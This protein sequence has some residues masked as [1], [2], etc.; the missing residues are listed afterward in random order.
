MSRYSKEDLLKLVKEN[1]VKFIRLQFTDVFGT[2]KNV[3]IM[4]DSLERVLD[5]GCM[6]DGSSIDGFVRIEE[7]DMYLQ[8]DMDTFEIFPWRPQQNRVARIIC[9]V[10]TTDGVPFKGCP[11][12]ILKKVLKEAAAMGYT[13]NVG[14]ECEFFLFHTD[15]EGKPTTI[16][17]D[18]G[19]YFDLAP[20]DR[21]EDARRDICIALEE[22][23]FN[24]EASHHE[25]ARGQHE[26][27][28]KY[29]EALKTA[30]NVMTF[31]LVVKAVAQ[32]HGLYAT[33][34][35]KPIFGINGSGMH[36]NQSLSKGKKNAFYDPNDKL[37]LS[38]E[39]Y[40]FIAGMMVHIKSFSAITN[41]LVN[42][43][44]RLVPGYEAP[45]YIAWSAKNRSP[46]IRVPAASG[47]ATRIE[48][49]NPDPACNPY[50]AF[51]LMLAAGLD[52]IKK[53]MKPVPSVDRNIFHMDEEARKQEG[54]D[55]M[56]ASLYDAILEMQKNPLVKHVLGDHIYDTYIEAKMKE[57][58][59]F[60]IAV[61]PWELEKYL[62]SF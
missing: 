30:D 20:I 51:A 23:G 46:L 43:Y 40:S 53:G 47:E 22:M 16:T 14:P 45:C 33:F 38:A 6:F 27:D 3:A 42:S 25:V 11:R 35:P 5:N 48:V 58:D 50:L 37:Q 61:H 8:P 24:I 62:G 4:S 39:A 60:R 21:G 59:Q 10:Y 28:F 18:D 54:V 13:F 56:P 36:C 32:R 57:W 52:G 9:D 17:H 34:M 7:S 26:I 41:P 31:K 2:L 49:R 44:K 1:D 55:S 29:E 19:S 15:E 12:F